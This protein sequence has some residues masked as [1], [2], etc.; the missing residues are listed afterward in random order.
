MVGT[1]FHLQFEA[2][3]SNASI[4]AHSLAKKAGVVKKIILG[5]TLTTAS[6]GQSTEF[7]QCVIAYTM[8]FVPKR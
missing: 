7:I 3:Q 2:L 6:L 4:T 1:Q 8:Q 5:D